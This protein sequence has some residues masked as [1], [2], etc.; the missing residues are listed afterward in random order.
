M[1]LGQEKP[2]KILIVDDVPKNIQ[3]AANILRDQQYQMAF[4]QNGKHALEQVH[5]NDFDLILLDIMMPEMDGLTV[6]RKLKED[7]DTRDIPVIFLTARNDTEDIVDGFERGAVD[8][9]TKPFNG[10]ELLARVKTHLSLRYAREILK[11]KNNE[12]KTLNATKDKFFSIIAHDLKNPVQSLLLASDILSN[13]FDTLDRDRI[14]D[15]LDRFHASTQQVS[16]LLQ[17]LLNWARSQQN[18]LKTNPQSI[19]LFQMTDDTVKLLAAQAAEKEI[20]LTANVEQETFA[21][22]DFNMVKTVLR[23]LM[24]NALKF[25]PKG[26]RITIDACQNE[27]P[28]CIDIVVVDTGVGM[29]EKDVDALFRI[30]TQ[31]TTKGTSGETGTGL[32]LILCKEFIAKNNGTITADSKEGEGSRFTITLPLKRTDAETDETADP[33][34]TSE[35]A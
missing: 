4:A 8:Y 3:V 23:N 27:N 6:C 2:Y 13:Y 29:S 15:F 1:D 11:Q 10:A 16:E 20:T 19:D 33:S 26:G 24:S 32:G 25:T 21:Y 7:P 35:T 5:A 34:E 14:K 30:D 17:N 22:G 9:V 12:L 28:D 31:R 18:L